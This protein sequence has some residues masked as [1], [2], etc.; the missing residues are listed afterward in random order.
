MEKKKTHINTNFP[1]KK[2]KGKIGYNQETVG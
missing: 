1:E 2:N